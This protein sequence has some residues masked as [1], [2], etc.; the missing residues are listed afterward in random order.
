MTDG[1]KIYIPRDGEE[2][3]QVQA[4]AENN[5]SGTDL[6]N[7]NS[8]SGTELESLAGVG[9]VT[10]QK[11][12]D[13]RPYGSVEELLDKKIVGNATFEKIKTSISIQ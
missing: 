5:T 3:Q 2:V 9:V 4:Q 7:I 6:I 11:I 1:L 10:A 12:I 8:A 13:G